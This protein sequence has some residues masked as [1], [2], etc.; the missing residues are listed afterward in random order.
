MS[1]SRSQVL[2]QTRLEL[3]QPR[4]SWQVFGERLFE[5]KVNKLLYREQQVFV[6]WVWFVFLAQKH[7]EA[8]G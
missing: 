5:A 4:G 8:V 2:T 7:F 3:A 1:N 6:A